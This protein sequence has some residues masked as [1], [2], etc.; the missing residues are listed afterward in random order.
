M[1]QQPLLVVSENVF[2]NLI[3]SNHISYEKSV[4][5]FFDLVLR[6]LGKAILCEQVL[7]PLFIGDGIVRVDL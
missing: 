4:Y 6:L 7:G 5:F 3:F 1:V 2:T